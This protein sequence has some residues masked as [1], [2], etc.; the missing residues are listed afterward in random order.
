MIL[1]QCSFLQRDSNDVF[2]GAEAFNIDD[3]R[4]ASLIH[5]SDERLVGWQETC[6]D[7][8]VEAVDGGYLFHMAMESCRL[9]RLERRTP[10]AAIPAGTGGWLSKIPA[11]LFL[12]Y[13]VHGSGYVVTLHSRPAVFLVDEWRIRTRHCFWSEM[14]SVARCVLGQDLPRHTLLGEC[15]ARLAG[16]VQWPWRG[17]GWRCELSVAV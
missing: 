6:N 3:R 9:R 5:N 2:C 17:R 10:T 4:S 12:S 14:R 7:C 16:G 13:C 15:R 1:I 8:R 11:V